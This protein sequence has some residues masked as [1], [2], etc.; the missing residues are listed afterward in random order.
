[1]PFSGW[2]TRSLSP[3]VYLAGGGSLMKSPRVL[4]AA[5]I[6]FFV[7]GLVFVRFDGG[8]AVPVVSAVFV[9]I[10]ALPSYVALWQ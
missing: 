1:M 9:V 5:A 6:A 10:L 7:V 2:S 3:R 8:G 4:T